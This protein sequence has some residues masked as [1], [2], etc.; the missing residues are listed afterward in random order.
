MKITKKEEESGSKQEK[1]ERLY[2][3]R[4][5]EIEK[6]MFNI[7]F[8]E[9]FFILKKEEDKENDEDSDF[10]KTN[11]QEIARMLEKKYTLSELQENVYYFFRGNVFGIGR[12]IAGAKEKK[13]YI[14]ES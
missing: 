8:M 13:M 7:K 10:D 12:T 14:N 4:S 11:E 1:R 3:E 2:R 5:K 9:T 6:I